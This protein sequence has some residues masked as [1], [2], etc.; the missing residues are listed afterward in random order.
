MELNLVDGADHL[1]DA[2]PGCEMNDMYKF[3]RSLL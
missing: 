3:I 2:D 1:F